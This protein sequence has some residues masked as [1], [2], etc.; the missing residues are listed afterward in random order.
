M[1]SESMP[2]D[3]TR[4]IPVRRF[5]VLVVGAGPAG[6]AAAVRASGEGRVVALV[7]DN[8]DLGG[9]IWRNERAR[10]T[11]RPA[12]RWFALAA[13]APFERLASTRIVGSAGPGV[14]VAESG[15]RLV[16][17]EYGKLIL[18]T[19]ARE[20]FLPFPG[21]TLP[22]VMGAG[23]LQAMVKSGLPIAGKSVVVAGSGPLLLAVAA[24]LK[25]KGA[26]VRAIVEQAP[27]G[28]ARPVRPRPPVRAGQVA[29]GDRPEA[30]PR[31]GPL[32]DGLVAGRGH[33]GRL[34]GPRPV[35]ITDGRTI[36]EI[37]CDY[38]ACGFGLLPNLE[39]PRLLGCALDPEIGGGGTRVDPFGQTTIPGVYAVGEV[40]GIGGLEAATLEG[41]VAG[42]ASTGRVDRATA[43]LPARA[44]ARRFARHLEAAFAP[45]AELRKPWPAPTRSSAD[46][47]TCPPPPSSAAAPGSTPSSRPAAG[48][49]PA[50]AGSAEAPS[51][52]S[53]A[54]NPPRS[55]RRSSPSASNTWPSSTTPRPRIRRPARAD[56][57]QNTS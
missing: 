42:Y 5:D 24:A 29:P 30:R 44:R 22:N 36:R 40:T 19:G 51:P 35:A 10:P 34:G 48:W 21:W 16:E 13:A 25:K 54:G 11:G 31:P 1:S 23:G 17:L 47:R 18:A 46:A 45:R 38:L 52:S 37:P 26:D 8:P 49:A 27:F 4:P 56:K 6:M 41:E 43:L 3:G 50:R 14:L 28:Q 39:L 53:T 7:D 55:A 20:L 12:A 9:Q 15:G 2:G 32:P 33:A 57:E